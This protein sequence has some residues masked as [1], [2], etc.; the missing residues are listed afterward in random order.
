ME[1]EVEF[2]ILLRVKD[3]FHF[4]IKHNYTSFAGLFGVFLSGSAW[5]WLLLSFPD[6]SAFKNV[7][8]L[9]GGLLFTVVQPIQLYM[10]AA[11][12]IKLNPMFQEPILYKMGNNGITVSQKNET[13]PIAWADVYKVVETKTSII[14]YLSTIHAYIF[15]KEQCK[16]QQESI[17]QIIKEYVDSNKCKWKKTK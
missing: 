7:L 15:P 14:L 9:I 10:K 3:M 8:L 5:V 16:E 11:Q 1:K 2:S 6:N 17:L 13:L 12:Q 4:L